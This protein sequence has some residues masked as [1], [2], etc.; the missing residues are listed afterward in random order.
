MRQHTK[1]VLQLG[2]ILAFFALVI[3]GLAHAPSCGEGE[4][5]VRAVFGT[6]C[7]AGHR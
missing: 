5:R 7:V 1:D 6:A 2:A 3:F 4:V